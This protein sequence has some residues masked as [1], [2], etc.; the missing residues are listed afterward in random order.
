MLA[1]THPPGGDGRSRQASPGG[2]LVGGAVSLEDHRPNRE[3][4]Q[5][6]AALCIAYAVVILALMP[7]AGRPLRA[8][9][10]FTGIFATAVF[11]VDVCTFVLLAAQF[12]AGRNTWLLMLACAY[13]FSGIMAALHLATFPGAV[14]ADSAL[15]GLPPTVAWL[16]LSWGLGFIVLLFAA[17]LWHARAPGKLA[18]AWSAD[19]VLAWSVAAVAAATGLLYLLATAGLPWLP[20]VMSGNRFSGLNTGIDLCRSLFAVAALAI[21]W[22]TA[23]QRSNVVHLWLSLAL[24]AAAAGPVLTNLGGQ[25]FTFGWYAGRLSFAFASAVVLCVL[26]AEFVRL[27]HALARTVDGL[28]TQT[29][30]LQSEIERRE[31]TEHQL[32]HSQKMEAIGRVAGGV[33]HDFNN[34]LGAVVSY[35]ELILRTGKD[36]QVRNYAEKAKQVSLRGARLTRSLV[37]FAQRQPLRAGMVRTDELL[38]R[39]EFLMHKAVGESVTLSVVAA[40]DTWPVFVDADQLEIALLNLALNSRDAMPA[41]GVIRMTSENVQGPVVETATPDSPLEPGD[42]VVISVSDSGS[43]IPADHLEKVFDPFFTT[44]SVGK[45]SGLGLSQVRGFVRQSGGQ[46][47]IRSAPGQGTTVSLYLPR[48]H[49]QPGGDTIGPGV[50]AAVLDPETVPP[51]LPA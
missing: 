11:I 39:F 9:P 12:R 35:L 46:V 17:V 16:Y 5:L 36:E 22:T 7:F 19:S 44:K 23:R 24:V 14:F 30:A 43:G 50:Q 4:R 51:R 40:P 13:L 34:L 41:G 21:L 45:G 10:A 1:S 2:A 20:P 18:L 49:A 33:S 31:L 26:L 3:Q 47:A 42:Y 27:Q 25:R 48:A 37:A 28:Q 6:V 8:V 38:H 29:K 32:L 15:I